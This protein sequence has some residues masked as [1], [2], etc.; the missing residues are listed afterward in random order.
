MKLKYRIETKEEMDVAPFAGVWI[1]IDMT[2]KTKAKLIVAPF[3]GVW[4]EIG[5]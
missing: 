2:D 5:T 3:A 1:E 4:I